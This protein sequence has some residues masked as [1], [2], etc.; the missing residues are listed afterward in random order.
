[1]PRGSRVTTT[2]GR[3]QAGPP[4]SGD[5]RV[6]ARH[7]HAAARSDGVDR[8]APL[9]SSRSGRP[10]RSHGSPSHARQAS[11][12]PPPAPPRWTIGIQPPPDSAMRRKNT[13]RSPWRRRGSADG[14]RCGGFGNDRTG[15]NP[16]YSPWKSDWSV[17]HRIFRGRDVLRELP[18]AALPATAK[19][20]ALRVIPPASTPTHEPPAAHVVQ[21]ADLRPGQHRGPVPREHDPPKDGPSV[22]SS[23]PAGQRGVHPAGKT[24]RKGVAPTLSRPVRRGSADGHRR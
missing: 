2:R 23:R 9:S 10:A 16:T 18:P 17:V 6:V 24:A 21:R 12:H 4:T 14:A 5:T 8:P 19:R 20:G 7:D 1:M 3:G 13:G 11:P 15:G 22:A